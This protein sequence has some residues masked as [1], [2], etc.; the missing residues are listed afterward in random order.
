MYTGISNDE[1]R[2]LVVESSRPTEAAGSLYALSGTNLNG[3]SGRVSFVLGLM[4]PS[5]AVDAACASAM[6]AVNDAVADL[7]Q[8]KADLALA[9]GVQA[10]L[11]GRIYELRAEAMMLSPDGQC[12]TFDESANGYVRGEGCGVVVLK[13]LT[14]AEADGDRIW[15]VIRGS[16][17]NN[18]GTS[19]GL[20]VPHTPALI[21]VME[22]ALEDAGALPSDVDYVEAHGT[23]TAVG[24]PVELDAVA[25]VYGK[26][27]DTD[28][29]LLMGSVKT[30]IGHLE[31]AAGIAG[32][33]KA[34]LTVKTGVI[35]RHLHFQNPNPSFDWEVHPLRV[36]SDM[37]DWPRRGRQPRL[38]GVNSF[39]ITGTNAHMVVAEYLPGHD[40]DGADGQD[41]NTAGSAR[42]VA[43]SL[44]P[45]VADSPLVDEK[46]DARHTRLL[47]LSGKSDGALKDLARRYLSWLDEGAAA[48]SDDGVASAPLLSDASW[49]A[50][51][52]RSH[53][54][55]RAGVVFR[56][57]K[58]LRNRLGELAE[59]DAGAP[60]RQAGKVAFV[61]TGQGSQWV[62]MGKA[63]YETEPVARAVMDRCEK[64][65]RDVRSESL[66]DVMFGRPG[67]S[68]DLGDTA[69]EQ[70][71]LY[72]LGCALT[73]LWASVGV[74]PDVVLGH[75]VGEIA[76]AHTAGVFSLEDGM[77]LAATRGTLLSST[78]PG[79]M[80]AVFAPRERVESEVQGFN[81]ASDGVGLSIAAD[82]GAQVVVSGPA[83]D[84]DEI[85]KRFESAE[86]RAVRLNTTRAFH[87]ALVEPA[88]D[89]LE[90]FLDG[91][92]VKQPSLTVVSNV[93]GG[94]VDPGMALD[95]A[96]W[97]RHAREP[98][99]F[100]SGVGAMAELGVDL[101]VEMGPHS[102]LGPM[103]TMAWPQPTPDRSAP[104]RPP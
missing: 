10:I 104:A 46:L 21:Q 56:D 22:T 65:F 92:E 48:L 39:G 77:R 59:S 38:A 2:M 43:L 11:N 84:V 34:A 32:L 95:A 13:R 53:F 1:Y 103:T 88:L 52:G 45:S 91:V 68:G 29:P 78:A 19:L 15:A 66:L 86:V 30:N 72:A 99:A 6:V 85:V 4:G 82:N 79:G 93:T 28:R 60:P 36:T 55:R 100:A 33:I 96:Y 14:D 41:R 94:P 101:V 40:A 83:E 80:A 50:G 18:G 24:D 12:K 69:W 74:R 44:P 81:A 62:G 76:A 75:S 5:K 89:G 17:V 8:G 31:S 67:N 87:S 3:T 20:T 27:R 23:G 16:S 98:V 9:G 42:S 90:A 71:A 58:S 47:P 73:A 97:R 63:L 57:A 64:I 61:Y 102:V 51:V 7:Q 70:P 26:G 54:D 49:T 25:S 37:T 35:P